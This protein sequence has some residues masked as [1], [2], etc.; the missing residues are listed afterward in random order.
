MAGLRF[1]EG[2]S[3]VRCSVGF[4]VGDVLR[5]EGDGGGWWGDLDSFTDP[6]PAGLSSLICRQ[7]RLWL[8]GHQ[9]SR[10]NT[11]LDSH[12]IQMNFFQ[13]GSPADGG[14]E[15]DK[16]IKDQRSKD[17]RSAAWICLR[18]NKQ[19]ETPCCFLNTCCYIKVL[20]LVLETSRESSH[21]L[22]QDRCYFQQS[23]HHSPIS[24]SQAVGVRTCSSEIPVIPSPGYQQQLPLKMVT[25]RVP[26][27]IGLGGKWSSVATPNKSS[28]KTKNI[29]HVSAV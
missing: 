2:S 21:L 19:P 8:S 17:L 15:Q 4:N 11:L 10:L 20:L 16:T 5:V 6:S 1:Q 25:S 22:N 12:L 14:R 7:S 28:Q 23:T 3:T 27:E 24:Y 9:V 29:D 26:V 13:A 18:G